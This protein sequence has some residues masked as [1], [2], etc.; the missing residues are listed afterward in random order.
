MGHKDDA[1][2]DGRRIEERFKKWER[3]KQKSKTRKKENQERMKC[4]E[5]QEAPY[6]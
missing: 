1:H 2:M 3:E 5:S 4:I 6:R